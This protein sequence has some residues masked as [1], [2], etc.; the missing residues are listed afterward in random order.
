MTN[1]PHGAVQANETLVAQL[2]RMQTEKSPLEA[3]HQRKAELMSDAEKFDKLIEN[4][5][6][7]DLFCVT[8]PCS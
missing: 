8:T 3:A 6:V 5:Q 2:Q 7:Q 1:A 4:L